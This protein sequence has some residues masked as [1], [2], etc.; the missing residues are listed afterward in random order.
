MAVLTNTMM[1]G[2][3]A[4]SDEATSYLI[5]KSL[6]F[7]RLDDPSLEF[8]PSSDGNRTTWTWA[9]WVKFTGGGTGD[10]YIFGYGINNTTD[11]MGLAILDYSNQG[12]TWSK[13]TGGSATEFVEIGRALRD[14]SA[15]FHV[16]F[17]FNSSDAT[18][19]DRL[20]L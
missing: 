7:N 9:G 18:E 10:R 16:C 15:W 17:N 13:K 14:P 8:T 19:T 1:Q 11:R 6:R 4:I 20:R 12:I 2:T 5:E 3:A